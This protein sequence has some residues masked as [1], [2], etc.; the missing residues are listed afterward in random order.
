M[1]QLSSLKRLLQTCVCLMI[2]VAQTANAADGPSSEAIKAAVA[3]YRNK[4]EVVS[5]GYAACDPTAA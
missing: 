1:F 5:A 3:D 4:H 2:V